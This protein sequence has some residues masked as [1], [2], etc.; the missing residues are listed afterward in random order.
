MYINSLKRILNLNTDKKK[1][2]KLRHD[3]LWYLVYS[4]CKAYKSFFTGITMGAHFHQ[5][6]SDLIPLK[7]RRDRWLLYNILCPMSYGSLDRVYHT[8]YSYLKSMNHL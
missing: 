3:L 7:V 2:K 1:L 6:N 8:L 5:I 4:S